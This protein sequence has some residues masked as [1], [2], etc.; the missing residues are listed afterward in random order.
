MNGAPYASQLG[1]GVVPEGV[2][3]RVNAFTTLDFYGRYELSKRFSLHASIVNVL[4][5]GAPEDWGTY[6]GSGAPYNPAFHLQGA[7]GRFLSI[8][9]K[10]QF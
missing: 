4:N 3:C 1:S 2:K 8:G 7:V 10:Y 9:A 6:G 5:A